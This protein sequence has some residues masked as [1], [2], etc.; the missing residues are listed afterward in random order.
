[1]G[2]LPFVTLRLQKL[3]FFSHSLAQ[4]LISLADTPPVHALGGA[5]AASSKGN[6]GP[7]LELLNKGPLG[8]LTSAKGQSISKAVL[9]TVLLDFSY[10][11]SPSA[12]EE[13]ISSDET[14]S[15][16]DAALFSALAPTAAQFLNWAR[17][18]LRLISEVR[19]AVEA[20]RISDI[21]SAQAALASGLHAPQH[22]TG[23]QVR[24]F[25]QRKK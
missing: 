16:A 23:L 11:S 18:L 24:L 21:L 17:K 14:L 13:K 7:L 3:L 15:K 4:E 19:R 5:L 22:T 12:N 2:S 9:S 10:L 1:M 25:F 6:Q 8:P 20:L